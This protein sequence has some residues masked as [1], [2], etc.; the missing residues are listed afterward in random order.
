M[1][2]YQSIVVAIQSVCEDPDIQP[3]DRRKQIAIILEPMLNEIFGSDYEK[4]EEGGFPDD[5]P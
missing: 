3:R 2:A 4:H 5:K 1:K